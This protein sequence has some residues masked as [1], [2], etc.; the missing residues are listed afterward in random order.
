MSDA[1]DSL[2]TLKDRLILILIY[3]VIVVVA[4]VAPFSFDYFFATYDNVYVYRIFSLIWWHNSNTLPII[5]FHPFAIINNAL[6]SIL[7]FWFVFEIFRAYQGIES[8]KKPI[9]V[10]VIAEVWQLCLMIFFNVFFFSLP[11]SYFAI[12]MV[13]IPLLLVTGLIFLFVVPPPKPAGLWDEDIETT[14][15]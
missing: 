11:H 2:E 14:H 10:G 6:S 7:R 12:Y 3:T 1:I 4:I 9:L 15:N 8:R 5:V 13:P